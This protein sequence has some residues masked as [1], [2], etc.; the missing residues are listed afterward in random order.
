MV[1]SYGRG[2]REQ[3]T[4]EWRL[5]LEAR[6]IFV[7]SVRQ[8]RAQFYLWKWKRKFRVGG[9]PAQF[10]PDRRFAILCAKFPYHHGRV[11]FV[12][13]LDRPVD[14]R[15][16]SHLGADD[17]RG[18]AFIRQIKPWW[19]GGNVSRLWEPCTS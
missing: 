10:R 7:S 13:K 4:N 17:G 6:W 11:A 8:F 18:V 16:S 9:G 5:V 12:W 1:L 2:E 14:V 3:R 15:V 19:R